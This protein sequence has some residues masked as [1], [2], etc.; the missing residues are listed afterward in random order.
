MT[1]LKEIKCKLNVYGKLI[2]LKLFPIIT[3][4][5][6]QNFKAY[7][8]MYPYKIQQFSSEQLIGINSKNQFKFHKHFLFLAWTHRCIFCFGCKAL[9][10]AEAY[11]GTLQ[12]LIPKEGLNTHGL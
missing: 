5:N 8:Y 12:P 1:T 2:S 6:F 4:P 3:A 7:V 10:T 11:P 9:N